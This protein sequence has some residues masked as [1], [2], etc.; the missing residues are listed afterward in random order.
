MTRASHRESLTLHVSAPERAA[1][2]WAL[3]VARA[4]LLGD[5]DVAVLLADPPV[6]EAILDDLADRLVLA[7]QPIPEK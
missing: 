3:E 4:L 1:L 6:G 7:G 2:I 5:P